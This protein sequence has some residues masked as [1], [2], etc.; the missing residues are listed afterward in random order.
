M[1]SVIDRKAVSNMDGKALKI[2]SNGMKD[3][4]HPLRCLVHLKSSALKQLNLVLKANGFLGSCRD[5]EEKKHISA[6]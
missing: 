4:T 2:W 3:E 6:A 5:E 1:D